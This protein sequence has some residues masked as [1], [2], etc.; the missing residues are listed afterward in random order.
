MDV[1]SIYRDCGEAYGYV[2]DAAE[3]NVENYLDKHGAPGKAV[4]QALLKAKQTVALLTNLMVEEHVRGQGIGS[5]M[6]G[7]FLSQAETCGATCF[8]LIADSEEVQS[9]GFSLLEWYEGFGF[10]KVMDTGTGP[11][12]AM[13]DYAIEALISLK[14][15]EEENSPCP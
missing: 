4:R 6:V 13:G 14:V 8:I 11:L 7:D 1:V 3:E 15:P 12:M 10:E 2:V 5:D 9:N